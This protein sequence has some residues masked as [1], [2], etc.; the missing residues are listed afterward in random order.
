[1]HVR[2]RDRASIDSEHDQCRYSGE[3]YVLATR[4]TYHVHVLTERF[5]IMDSKCHPVLKWIQE[6]NTFCGRMLPSLEHILG[7]LFSN[8]GGILFLREAHGGPERFPGHSQISQIVSGGVKACA[9]HPCYS[10][11]ALGSLNHILVE[12]HVRLGEC[13]DC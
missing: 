4:N 13:A 6:S 5:V 1:M 8:V 2:Y 10:R 7:C 9:L 3:A 12:V 11:I